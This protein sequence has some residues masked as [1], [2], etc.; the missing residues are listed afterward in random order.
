MSSAVEKTHDFRHCQFVNAQI[1]DSNGQFVRKIG[2]EGSGPGQFKFPRG[3]CVDQEGS[4]IVADRNNDRV[5]QLT[6]GGRFVRHLLTRDDGLRAP[7]AVAISVSGQLV[8]T[9]SGSNRAAVK[10]FQI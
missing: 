2:S 1:F 3:L 8:V 4:V 10:V 7:Y 6:L 9:E 5:C